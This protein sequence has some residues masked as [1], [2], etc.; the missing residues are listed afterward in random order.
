MAKP[1]LLMCV[2]LGTFGCGAQT[3]APSRS[4][5]EAG[6]NPAAAS[7]GKGAAPNTPQADIAY[8][9]EH[10]PRLGQGSAEEAKRTDFYRLRRGRLYSVGAIGS[11]QEGELQKQLTAAT[12]EGNL[13]RI[14]E[15]TQGILAED[16]TDIRAHV[17]RAY[18]LHKMGRTAEGDLHRAMG[19]GLV[20]SIAHTGDGKDYASA[21]TV[22]Q[23]EEEYEMLKFA[24]LQPSAQALREHAGRKYDVLEALDPETKKTFQIFFDVTELFAEEGR[25][26][27]GGGTPTTR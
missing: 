3:A 1:Y 14:L 17:L 18:V 13:Q 15:L 23:V 25:M 26:L 10:A 16:P 4:P 6:A 2:W 20:D 22:F 19:Q 8:Y 7:T 21:W 9:Q 12:G 24:R 27:S 11:A 5:A